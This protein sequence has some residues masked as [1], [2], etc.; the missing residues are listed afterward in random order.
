M[1]FAIVSTVEAAGVRW[2]LRFDG[3]STAAEEGVVIV[4][5]K[6]TREAVAMS[7]KL[8]FSCTNNTVEYE[9]YLT[10][11]AVAREIGIKCLRMI[12][13]SNLVI[14]Q[15]K[16]DFA[17]KELS[18][19]PYRAMAQML[20]DSF[21][22]FDIQHSQ[23]SDN[24]FADALAILGAKISFEGTTTELTIIKKPVPIIQVLKEEFFGQPLDQA[25]W[26][27]PIKEALLSSSRKEQLKCFKDYTLVVGSYTE[28]FREES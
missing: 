16:G 23:R 21:E 6:E 13:D 1:A 27:S 5:I 20:E 26:R 9:A 10:S 4:P 28:N 19:A 3:S 8:D 15:A 12:G 2:V 11:L 17:L 7:F 14:C 25:D 18:L 24:R 22:D